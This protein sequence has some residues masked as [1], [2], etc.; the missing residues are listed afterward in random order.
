MFIKIRQILKKF[1]D[2]F[3][4]AN[5]VLSS[6]GPD[7]TVLSVFVYLGMRLVVLVSL[8]ILAHNMEDNCEIFTAGLQMCFSSHLVDGT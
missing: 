1:M 3:D 4:D 5:T 7:N 2:N 6:H 8:S